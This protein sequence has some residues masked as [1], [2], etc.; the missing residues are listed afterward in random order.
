VR[1]LTVLTGIVLGSSAATTFGLGATLVVFL[2][3]SG[4]APEFRKELPLLAVYVALFASLTA[5]AATSF[6]GLARNRPWRRWAQGAMWGALAGL[7][8]LYWYTRG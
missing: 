5:L 2:V 1:P 4:E 3:L 8:A 7:A 6:V